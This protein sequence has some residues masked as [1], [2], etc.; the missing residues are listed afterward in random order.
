[1]DSRGFTVIPLLIGL[2]LPAGCTD[3]FSPELVEELGAHHEPGV[4]SGDLRVDVLH[5]EDG[6]TITDLQEGPTGLDADGDGVPDRLDLDSDGDGIPDS[7]EAGDDDPLTWPRDTDG[8]GTPDFRDTDSDADGLGDDWEYENGLDPYSSDSDGDGIPDLIEVGSGTDPLDGSCG[9]G[10]SGGPD[11]GGRPPEDPGPAPEVDDVC[12]MEVEDP[13]VWYVSADDSNSMASPVVARKYI[14]EGRIVNGITIRTY[15]FTNYYDIGY[16]PARYM[17]VDVHAHMKP[18]E[19]EGHYNLQI[20][21]QGHEVT[22]YS[23][24][25]LNLTFVMDTSGSMGG[26][27]IELERDVCETIAG[28][29]RRGDV[30]SMVVWAVHDATILDSHAVTGPDD[31][32]LLSTCRSLTA[33]GGTDLH[34]GLTAGYALAEANHDAGYLNRVILVSDGQ[35]NVGITDETIIAEAAEDELEAGIYLVGVG[36]GY[37]Y[38]DTLMDAVT[39]A[40]KGAYVFVDSAEEAHAIFHERF[41]STLDVAVMDVR[42]EL[43]LPQWLRIQEFHGEEISTDPEEVKPQHLAPNDAMIYHQLLKTCEEP[44][45]DALVRVVARYTNPDT[46]ER[47]S[48]ELVVTVREL[49]ASQSDPE[50]RKGTAIVAYAEGLKEIYEL[51][52]EGDHDEAQTVCD[53]LR[54]DIGLEA[55]DMVDPDLWDIATLL[56]DYCS[57][58]GTRYW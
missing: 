55:I 33:G 36:V 48:S 24:R 46:R 27:P 1:M 20:G 18:A 29:L 54:R 21:V 31:P 10:S 28:R 40:G 22:P 12:E 51:K 13:Q 41:V 45:L 50:L 26:R 43:T 35:A 7:V 53:E 42:V 14:E 47:L 11:G 37:G 39:D 38:N 15:E 58:L 3:G 9:A 16:E 4:V 25:P 52:Q 49:L 32:T 17:D 5:D 30:V 19:E 56:A 44:V 34:G 8:D 23:R 6:D 2:S 57:D